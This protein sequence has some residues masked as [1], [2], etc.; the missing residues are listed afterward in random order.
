MSVYWTARYNYT[1]VV[2]GVRLGPWRAGEPVAVPRE[3]LGW[4]VRDAPDLFDLRQVLTAGDVAAARARFA[5][6]DAAAEVEAAAAVKAVR[7]HVKA[8]F[9]PWCALRANVAAHLADELSA[10][11][12]G[13]GGWL[14]GCPSC[15]AWHARQTGETTC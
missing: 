9:G 3:L 12:D 14:V 13:T 15:R 11:R 10:V 4:L 5:E 2:D 6:L 7:A 8:M 1:A